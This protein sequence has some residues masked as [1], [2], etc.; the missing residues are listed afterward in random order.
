M[1]LFIQQHLYGNNL[2]IYFWN[3]CCKQIFPIDVKFMCIYQISS[4]REGYDTDS[5][6]REEKLV[7]EFSFS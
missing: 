7:W 5:I 2:T 1:Y 4:P 3:Y 6:L